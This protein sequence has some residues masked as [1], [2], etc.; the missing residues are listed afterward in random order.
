[1]PDLATLR[2]KGKARLRPAPANV[3]EVFQAVSAPYQLMVE[4]AMAANG[5]PQT[6]TQVTRFVLLSLG[7]GLTNANDERSV[8]SKDDPMG[9]HP[10][11]ASFMPV[12][13]FRKFQRYGKPDAGTMLH[14]LSAVVSRVVG[15]VHGS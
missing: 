13:L 9:Y 6:K 15:P 10:W 14:K 7:L 11:L 5:H 3:V 1:M 4:E 2:P 8:W 12:H